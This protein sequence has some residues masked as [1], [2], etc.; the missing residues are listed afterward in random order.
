MF[1][2][3]FS[4]ITKDA[5]QGLSKL[6]NAKVDEQV[7]R[8]NRTANMQGDVIAGANVAPVPEDL[9]RQT[10]ITE[11]NTTGWGTGL[12]FVGGVIAAAVILRS[13]R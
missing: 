9:Q 2:N 4:D 8:I 3:L 1:E 12:M 13:L 10:T 5:K 7:A 11:A 6:L